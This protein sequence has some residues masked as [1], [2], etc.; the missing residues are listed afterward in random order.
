MQLTRVIYFVRL[1]GCF[2]MG[3]DAEARGRQVGEG[4]FATVRNPDIYLIKCSPK[5]PSPQQG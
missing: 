1:V 5:L 4:G 2:Q 3:K